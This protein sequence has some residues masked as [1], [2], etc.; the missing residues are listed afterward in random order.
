MLH[1]HDKTPEALRSNVACHI[2]PPK[3]FLEV[4]C[5]RD[6]LGDGLPLLN[7]LDLLL[8]SKI[9]LNKYKKFKERW[10]EVLNAHI[11]FQKGQSFQEFDHTANILSNSKLSLTKFRL[12]RKLQ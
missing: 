4:Y 8:M 5:S 9:H 1:T 11:T 7:L 2:L 12:L 6:F 10:R 3:S